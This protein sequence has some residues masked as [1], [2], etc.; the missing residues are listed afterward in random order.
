[1]FI[2]GPECFRL[3]NHIIPRYTYDVENPK[4]GMR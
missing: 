1:M 4:G 3:R 2:C